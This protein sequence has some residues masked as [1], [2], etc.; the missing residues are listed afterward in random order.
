VLFIVQV[1]QL[2]VGIA[3]VHYA[4]FAAARS[5]IVWIPSDASGVEPPNVFAPGARDNQATAY[6]NWIMRNADSGSF[7]LRKAWQAAAVACTPIAPSRRLIDDPPSVM[8]SDLAAFYR[9]LAPAGRGLG[10]ISTRMARKWNYASANTWISMAGVDRDSARGPTYNPYPGHWETRVD[11]FGRSY[12]YWIPWNPNEV[13]WED[14]VAVT[15]WHNFALLPGPARFLSTRLDR[16]SGVPDLVSELIV[17]PQNQYR[18]RV[19][20]TVLSATAT[21]SNEGLKSVLPY[22]QPDD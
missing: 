11:E 15:V 19:S 22:A 12:P 1:S 8:A 4:A 16:S 21:I 14:A 20:A 9:A 7:K 17:R 3:V 13:G 2:M 10:N 18:D 5:A 6:P